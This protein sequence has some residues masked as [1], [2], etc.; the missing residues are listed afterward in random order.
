MSSRSPSVAVN[1]ATLVPGALPSDTSTLS[2][3]ALK[4]GSLSFTFTTLIIIT[5]VPV[6]FALS[7]AVRVSE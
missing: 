2:V 1:L 3:E 4:T 5:V 7:V 6:L